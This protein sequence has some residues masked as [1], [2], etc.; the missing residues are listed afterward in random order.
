MS[1]LEANPVSRRLFQRVST[2]RLSVNEAAETAKDIVQVYGNG[3][4]IIN[5]WASL[6]ATNPQRDLLRWAK[7]YE[8]RIEPAPVWV[9]YRNL[10]D[11]SLVRRRH[12]VLYPHEVLNAIFKSG[13]RSFQGAFLRPDGDEG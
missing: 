7:T 3:S 5:G 8:L 6:T 12:Y 4:E 11:N 2:G 10:R 9:T 1:E 13:E